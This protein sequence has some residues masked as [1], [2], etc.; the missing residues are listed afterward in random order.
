MFSGLLVGSLGW[1]RAMAA[2][3]GDNQARALA[4]YAAMQKY[5]YKQ[6]G[7]HLY[8]EQYPAQAND[9]PYSY[10][11]PFSQAHIATIDLS[12]IPGSVGR[13]Y[14]AAVADRSLGQEH[15]WNTTGT[16]G[17][18]GYDSY[19]R[20]PYGNGGDKFYDDNE[21]V[22]LAKLQ[23][24]LMTGDG[25]A[26]KR[27][28]EIFDLIVSG[29]DTDASHPAPGGVFWTQ[30]T[31]SHDRNTV[32]NMPGAE[33]GLRLYQIT[34]DS[35]YL[36]WAR[37]MYEWTNAHLLAPN[38][39]YWDHI[40]L[41]GNIEKTQW[42]YNQGVPVGVNALFYK[43]TG[44]ETYLRRAE[45]IASAALDFYGADDR[46]YGQPAFF[47]S[48]FF[49]NLLLLQSMNHNPRYVQAMQA[50]ADKAWD[51]YRDT[52]TGLFRFNASQPTTQLLEQAAMTQIYAVL[53]WS[54]DRYTVLY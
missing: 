24:Y 37:K 10:E 44:D 20:P 6:D 45:D 54:P 11:W 41:A 9:N 17:L 49:K 29:W 38:G 48:I 36:D 52:A 4:S 40:D 28:K 35:N 3:R 15:Y 7:S 13:G 34:H 21:W 43:A 26:L 30:A 12:Y 16:T 8:L 47:N 1:K 25:A 27:A 18:A 14:G 42:S 5:F 33:M 32:S 50:Y 39:L 2:G 22:G 23:L 53:S 31:W 46:L 19:P 51:S